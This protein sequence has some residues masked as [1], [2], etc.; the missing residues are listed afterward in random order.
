MTD[1]GFSWAADRVLKEQGR[2]FFPTPNELR[3]HM[4][5]DVGAPSPRLANPDDVVG[6]SVEEWYANGGASQLAEKNAK[7]NAEYARK[8]PQTWAV[9]P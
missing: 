6:M 3:A 4:R 2:T 7:I 9:R 1:P 5:N 8:Y